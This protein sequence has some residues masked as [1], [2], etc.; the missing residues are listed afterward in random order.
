MEGLSFIAQEKSLA[1]QIDALAAENP[2]AA[3]AFVAQLSES[4]VQGELT[5]AESAAAARLICRFL[6]HRKNKSRLVNCISESQAIR[7]AVFGCL[8]TY[9]HS[10]IYL[11]K[12]IIRENDLELTREIITLLENNPFSDGTAKPC[13][14][15]WSSR[16]N[17]EGALKVPA[18]YLSA[19]DDAARLAAE[20]IS[21]NDSLQ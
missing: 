9:K 20:R 21:N 1:A 16:I 5:R 11:L 12:R 7:R 13:S 4:A 2:E 17:I 3:L 14:D 10:L 15:K 8:N 19:G 18:E 6:L